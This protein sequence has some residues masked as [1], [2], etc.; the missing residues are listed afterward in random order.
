MWG[1]RTSGRKQLKPSSRSGCPPKS[2]LTRLTTS[3]VSLLRTGRGGAR[4]S[5]GGWPGNHRGE[6][7]RWSA[8]WVVV[9]NAPRVLEV[10]HDLQEGFVN[11]R[12][13][14]L[15]PGLDRTHVGERI[16]GRFRA[17][18]GSRDRCWRHLRR[19]SQQIA[20]GK[21]KNS[22]VTLATPKAARCDPVSAAVRL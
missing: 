19:E 17:H 6:T 15:E 12:L 13:G 7:P 21:S 8:F 2:C 16:L 9:L 11:L 22:R 5:R 20:L 18:A 14:R 4:Q 3:G 1:A 10:P